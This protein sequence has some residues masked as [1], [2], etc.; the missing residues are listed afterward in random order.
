MR[1][2]PIGMAGMF[3]LLHL[4]LFLLPRVI[5]LPQLLRLPQQGAVIADAPQQQQQQL[6]QQQML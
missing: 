2:L 6:M 3:L 1:P 5:A 4:L